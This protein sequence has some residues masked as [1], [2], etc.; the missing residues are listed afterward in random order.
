MISIKKDF[1]NPP[2]LLVQSQ[3]DNHI[4]DALINKNKHSFNG[5][6][7]REKTKEA[8]KL[9]YKNKCAYCE[10]DTT[11]GASL[12]VEHFRPKAKIEGDS[13]HFGYYWLAYEWSNLTICCSICNK[14]KGNNF[15]ILGTRIHQP[16][17]DANGLPTSDYLRLNSKM[18]LGEQAV[19]INPEIDEVEKHF[20]F[21]PNGE[22]KGIDERGKA[23][24]D[25]LDL[26]RLP[27]AF[28]R[29]KILKKFVSRLKDIFKD[30]SEKII[31]ENACKTEVRRILNEIVLLSERDEE[32]SRFGFFIFHKFEFFVANEFTAESREK[33][34]QFFDLFKQGEL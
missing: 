27:L 1:K 15:P 22:I 34:L 21:L 5:S 30:L 8:L 9:L 7:Y 10:T 29:R 4:K 31:T 26:N 11:A 2:Q 6:I 18:L 14:K 25:I 16:L 32:Y 17:L 13:T 3:R 24:I 23:T 20:Y 19:L 33:L 28:H 12:E